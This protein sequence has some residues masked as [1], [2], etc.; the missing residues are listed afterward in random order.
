MADTDKLRAYRVG[1]VPTLPDSDR[2]YYAEELKR[3][4]DAIGL[5][6]ET[7]KKLEARMTSHGI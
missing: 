5:L 6:I 3:V 7:M 4:S 2:R 1:N